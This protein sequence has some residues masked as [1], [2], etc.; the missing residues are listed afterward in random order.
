MRPTLSCEPPAGKPTIILMVWPLGKAPCAR[1]PPNGIR[2]VAST[3]SDTLRLVIFICCCPLL[4]WPS[5]A[6]DANWSADTSY[7]VSI[8]ALPPRPFGQTVSFV[9]PRRYLPEARCSVA[10]VPPEVFGVREGWSTT[11]PLGL[12]R[13]RWITLKPIEALY[14]FGLSWLGRSWHIGVGF[15]GDQLPF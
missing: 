14:I 1:A 3:P 7:S 10:R 6:Q 5:D 12:L 13:S 9:F 2:P 15:E 4:T 11:I 8:H